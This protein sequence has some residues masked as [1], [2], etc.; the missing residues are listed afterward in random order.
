[1]VLKQPVQMSQSHY[2]LF[3]QLYPLNA[4]PIQALNGRPVHDAQ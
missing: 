2:K 4:R 3:I 1:M